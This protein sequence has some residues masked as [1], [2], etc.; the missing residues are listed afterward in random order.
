MPGPVGVKRLSEEEDG[1][2]L[3]RRV[4]EATGVKRGAPETAGQ[5]IEGPKEV[6]DEVNRMWDTEQEV[7]DE[8]RGNSIKYK[9][10]TLLE[11]GFQKA[12]NWSRK[13]HSIPFNIRKGAYEKSGRLKKDPDCL[14]MHVDL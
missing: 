8:Y 6:R 5:E 2:R 4:P 1:P 12:T 10:F 13:K 9:F 7:L 3:R 14:K 11:K